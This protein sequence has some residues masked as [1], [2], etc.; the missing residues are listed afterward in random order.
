M[1][2]DPGFADATLWSQVTWPFE[3]KSWLICHKSP[4]QP[5]RWTK[6]P[7][8]CSTV[9]VANCHNPESSVKE[10]SNVSQLTWDTKENLISSWRSQVTMAKE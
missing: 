7:G 10:M 1:T 3:K 9:V 2:A 6:I 4:W 5:K 8:A